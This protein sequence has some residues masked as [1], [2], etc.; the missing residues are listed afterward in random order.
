M[1]KCRGSGFRL[2][3]V[4]LKVVLGVS[5]VLSGFVSVCSILNYMV[6]YVGLFYFRCLV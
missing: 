6:G 4:V 5:G 3:V 2:E 1:I